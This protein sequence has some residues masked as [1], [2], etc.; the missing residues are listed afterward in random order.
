MSFTVVGGGPAGCLIAILLARRGHSVEIFERRGDPQSAPA[1]AGRSINL[2]LAARGIRAL[3]EAGVLGDIAGLA[4]TLQGRMLHEPDCSEQ[5]SPYG[6]R[7]DEVI[8]SISRA[9]LTARLTAAARRLPNV[10]VNFSTACI[11]YEGE[12]RLRLRDVNSGREFTHTARRVIGA[13]GA[14]SA[15]RQALAAHLKFD[16]R[17][18]RLDHDYKELLVP[19]R[20]GQPQLAMN[21]LH[22]W[23]R[24]GFMLIALPNADGSFTA[25]LFLSRSGVPGFDHLQDAA[26]VSAFFAREFPQ[27]Q[28][29]IPDLVGQFLAHPQGMLGTV[30]CPRWREDERLV[31]IGD[32]AHAIVPFHGQG[33][34]CAFEDCRILD[35]LLADHP[36]DAFA[37]FEQARRADTEAIAR[38]ALEN[39][40][41]MR[42]AVL[43]PRFQRQKAVA[44][45]LE[46]RHPAHFI[47]RY[48]MV[49]FHDRIPYSVALDRGQIQQAI[50]DAL[51]P[52][53]AP[54][55]YEP[56][57]VQADRLVTE[58][59]APISR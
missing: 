59:L 54:A 28:A 3:R 27:A 58:R 30:H 14:G 12:G 44:M 40:G 11:G 22:I 19:L 13:D 24:G 39:Y 57:W 18:D 17:E 23:P 33:M 31:L 42:D 38:M 37:R 41:E 43:E 16:V 1:E 25:T 52:V 26:A 49:M 47:P 7:E 21:A 20:A 9:T 6:Q 34:N 36:Q 56:D 53:D 50:L 51:V 46:R 48:A 2:A 35:E 5:F 8:H 55:D 45:A 15:L 4:V 32:A 29:L 10:Q